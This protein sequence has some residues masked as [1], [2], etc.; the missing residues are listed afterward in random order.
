MTG[1]EILSAVLGAG[2][3]AAMI[4]FIKWVIDRNDRIKKEQEEEELEE[5][6]EAER[7]PAMFS[8][9][10][11]LY[12]RMRQVI[13]WPG[14]TRVVL[15]KASDSGRIPRVGIPIFVTIVAEVYRS[16]YK[17]ARGNWFHR[18]VDDHYIQML[19]DLV[20]NEKTIVHSR[21][22]SPDNVLYDTYE[23]TGTQH[24]DI[25]LVLA[26]DSEMYYLSI[27]HDGEAS[28]DSHYREMVLALVNSTRTILE[29]ELAAVEPEED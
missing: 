27:H 29:E 24:S 11:K 6:L 2:G 4:S 12:D 8:A 7:I 10:G 21:D 17:S 16:G 18:P 20:A 26:K 28:E 25:R 1:V 19:V 23:I 14:C 22:L 13:D 15:L 3:L 9:F 5:E